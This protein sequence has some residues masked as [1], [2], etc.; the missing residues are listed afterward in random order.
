MLQSTWSIARRS[1]IREEEALKSHMEISEVNVCTEKKLR[2]LLP[3]RKDLE[4]I[5]N[6][7]VYGYLFFSYDNNLNVI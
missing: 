2:F 4:Q 6:K 3:M 1:K 7:S 5:L